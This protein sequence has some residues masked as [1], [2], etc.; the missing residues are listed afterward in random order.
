[1]DCTGT[2]FVAAEVISRL[3]ESEIFQI[4]LF[5]FLPGRRSVNPC[6]VPGTRNLCNRAEFTDG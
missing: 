5:T 3:D 6:I 4:R 1:M 2:L